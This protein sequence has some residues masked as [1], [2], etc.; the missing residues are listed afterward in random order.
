M[1][2]ENLKRLHHVA[3]LSSLEIWKHVNACSEFDHCTDFSSLYY[4]AI[5][6]LKEGCVRLNGTPM[7]IRRVY[8]DCSEV[9]EYSRVG[10]VLAGDIHKCMICSKSFGIMRYKLHCYACGNVVCSRCSTGDIVMEE[11]A[12]MGP[13]HVCHQCYCGQVSISLP[14]FISQYT[15]VA[16]LQ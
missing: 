5:S 13:Q 1:K 10:L 2:L 8:G 12:A 9:G 14:S 15:S 7:L 6:R 11:A 3:I 4:Q 16:C